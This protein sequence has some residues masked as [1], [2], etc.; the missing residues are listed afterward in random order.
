MAEADLKVLEIIE[1]QV[2]ITSKLMRASKAMLPEPAEGKLPCR[3]EEQEQILNHLKL[4][5]RSGGSSKVLYV[6]GMPG[7][8]KTASV[9]QA[10]H[11]LQGAK[12]KF[13]FVHVNAMCLGNPAAVFGEILRQLSTAGAYSANKRGSAGAAQEKLNTFFDCRASVDLP[14]VL[15]IDE[16]DYLATRNQAVL[17]RIFNWLTLTNHRLIMACISNTMDL[18]ERLLPRVSSRFGLVRV[19][20][21]PYKR[22]QINE[23]LTQRLASHDA[24]SAFDPII[25]KLC[26]ARVAAGSGDIRKALQL[27][28][29]ALEFRVEK[30]TQTGSVQMEHLK[31]AEKELLHMNPSAG[32][33][34]GL[35]VKARLFL[36]ALLLEMRKREVE[37]VPLK[38]V[39]TRYAKLLNS[40]NME[41]AG[42]DSDAAFDEASFLVRRLQAMSLI[43]LQRR[44]LQ[45]QF[46]DDE[47][48]RGPTISLANGGLDLDDLSGALQSA[49]QDPAIL[50]LLRS[51]G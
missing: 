14:V 37:A 49:E 25:L 38:K 10:I 36:S 45:M 5:I 2:S 15:L 41:S 47:V 39:A 16:V 1:K 18:P 35:G 24:S 7:T 51:I 46:G 11:Q 21:Q 48:I 17:Y 13:V 27:C 43:S 30:K 19:D 32:A 40:L 50:E 3:D 12:Q 34:D 28:K 23:I 42:E 8:G 20:F 9:L 22:D 26:A 33:I 29:R 4:A 6:S 44:S 31:L